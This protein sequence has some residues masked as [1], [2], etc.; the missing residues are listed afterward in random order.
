M[1][2]PIDGQCITVFSDLLKWIGYTFAFTYV[3]M[4][5]STCV[6]K[7]VCEHTSSIQSFE[8]W[9]KLGV[10]LTVSERSCLPLGRNVSWAS[11]LASVI[12]C[13]FLPPNRRHYLPDDSAGILLRSRRSNDAIPGDTKHTNYRTWESGSE[14]MSRQRITDS[15]T[16]NKAPFEIGNR[17]VARSDR[18]NS[19]DG[20]E[21]VSEID[22]MPLSSNRITAHKDTSMNAI[23][24]V[25]TGTK[26]CKLSPN[27]LNHQPHGSLGD[28]TTVESIQQ[29]LN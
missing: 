14:R 1:F 7:C 19:R 27:V 29:I 6:Y 11:L 17:P 20:M 28:T 2:L 16:D 4:Y 3:Y 25:C 15:T 8:L 13:T 12:G 23:I 9:F 21:K 18:P 10:T 24:E 26:V 5:V 22:P